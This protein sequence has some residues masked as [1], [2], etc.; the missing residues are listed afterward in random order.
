M[1]EEVQL[2]DA[3]ELDDWLR[4]LDRRVD[5]WLHETVSFGVDQAGR[6]LVAH[7]PGRIKDL[8]ETDPP[9]P[10]RLGGDVFEGEAFVDP[11]HE[12]YPGSGGK[13][14]SRSDYPFYVDVGTGIYGPSGTPISSF[15]G[16]VMG[17]IE[18]GGQMIYARSVKGQPAQNYSERSFLDV[19]AMVDLR[20]HVGS[21]DDR[22]AGGR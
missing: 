4:G 9:P 19:D 16:G 14:S 21:L 7:A 2:A 5:S 17:P 3:R 18:Y 22:I 15:P 10:R 8:V 12:R 1:P 20:V 6:A 13:K 11:D